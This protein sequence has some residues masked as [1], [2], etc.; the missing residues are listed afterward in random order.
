[1]TDF[2]IALVMF[3]IGWCS[4]GIF[5]TL[6]AFIKMNKKLDEILKVVKE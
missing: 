1:M 3:C 6:L 4:C 2:Q 5:I